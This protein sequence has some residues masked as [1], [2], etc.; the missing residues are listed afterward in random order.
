M[1]SKTHLEICGSRGKR[2]GKVWNPEQNMRKKIKRTARNSEVLVPQCNIFQ[3]FS[4][5]GALV[6]WAQE[7]WILSNTHS[8][9]P[10]GVQAVQHQSANG[11]VENMCHFSLHEPGSH[12][13]P[14]QHAK[15][16]VWEEEL[17]CMFRVRE[18]N[19]S[20]CPWQKA[21]CVSLQ[22]AEDGAMPMYVVYT[23]F[24]RN[25]KKSQMSC[26]IPVRRLLAHQRR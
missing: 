6:T 2:E 11:M 23:I 20:S 25:W 14:P 12:P 5:P 4:V 16:S 21:P 8:L 13:L 17:L 9:Y 24:P 22:Q 18:S 15:H 3:Q 26:L 1:P 19:P 10:C 7:D